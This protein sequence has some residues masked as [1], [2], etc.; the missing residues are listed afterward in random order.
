MTLLIGGV[1]KDDPE[2]IRLNYVSQG[3]EY[4]SAIFPPGTDPEPHKA[5]KKD[6]ILIRKGELW[7]ANIHRNYIQPNLSGK[8]SGS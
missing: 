8:P 6:C 5:E 1:K 2:A 4:T 7:A 3:L